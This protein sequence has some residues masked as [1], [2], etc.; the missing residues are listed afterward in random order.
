MW[1]AHSLISSEQ[2]EQIAHNRSFVSSDLSD[3]LTVTPFPLN[4]LSD[5]LRVTHLSWAIWANCSQSL[6][7][8]ERNE[9]IP[10]PVLT[11][12][13]S[14]PHIAT[15]SSSIPYV[16]TTSSSLTLCCCLQ[17][18]HLLLC[19]ATTSLSITLGGYN[20]T[21]SFTIYYFVLLQPHYLLL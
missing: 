18:Y 5:S 15:T 4:N 17:P 10:S 14:I 3:S 13:S 21:T 9:R 2:P 16:A 7:W 6:I 19:V 11:D 8:F 20:G 12:D 1:I